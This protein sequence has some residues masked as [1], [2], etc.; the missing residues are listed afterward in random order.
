MPTTDES[1]RDLRVRAGWSLRGLAAQTGVAATAIGLIE[2][3]KQI[4][5]AVTLRRLAEVFRLD[6]GELAARFGQPDPTPTWPDTWESERVGPELARWRAWAGD[7]Q[8]DL[9]AAAECA[10][11]VVR[12]VE[13]GRRTLP[14]ALARVAGKRYGFDT[15]AALA[16]AGYD[17]TL[18]APSRWARGDFAELWPRLRWLAGVSLREVAEA[19]GVSKAAVGYWTERGHEPTD[20]QLLL[21]AGLLADRLGWHPAIA[22]V[23]QDALAKALGRSRRRAAPTPPHAGR[24]RRR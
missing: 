17:T 20:G 21:L 13:Q 11:S 3:G 8:H 16:A 19:V 18:P 4:P 10:V 1:L 12:E 6:V 22:G 7:R 14:V 23:D 9:A 15:A 5:R 24:P 2:R